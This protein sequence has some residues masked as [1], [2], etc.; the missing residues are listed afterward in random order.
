VAL[1]YDDPITRSTFTVTVYESSEPL[2]AVK[3]EALRSYTDQ[4]KAFSLIRDEKLTKRGKDAEPEAWL[5]EVESRLGDVTL[6]Q[7]QLFTKRAGEVF[8]L[9]FL[10]ERGSFVKLEPSVRKSLETFR[11]LEPAPVTR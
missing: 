9:S 6:R 8:L 3:K 5:V 7:L 1:A 11:F 10:A 4:F 2:L